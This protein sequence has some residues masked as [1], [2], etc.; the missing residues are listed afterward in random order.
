[1]P[2]LLIF[3]LFVTLTLITQPVQA[4]DLHQW[5][6]RPLGARAV[7]SPQLGF[8]YGSDRRGQSPIHHGLDYLNPRGTPVIA[9]GDGTVIFAGADNAVAVGL[10]PNFYG[11]VVIIQHNLNAPEGGA[12]FTLYGH[13]Y[14]IE[15]TVGQTV[16][17]G[18]QIGQVGATG[19]AIGSHLHFEVRVGDGLNYNATRNPEMW[20]PPLPGTGALIGRM[21]D[22]NGNLVV[23][24][25]YAITNESSVLP[26]FTYNDPNFPR[27]PVFNENMVMS[28]I[29]AGCY[30]IK[31]RGGAGLSY[32]EPICFASGETKV[33]E[34][35][36]Y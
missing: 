12:V 20:Y 21:V 7:Q 5:L 27:D 10:Y 23:G 32:N 19:I 8:T 15:V 11:N 22:G 34:I 30:R 14:K 33:L 18:Q 31:V 3:A 24:I 9:A 29:R 25:R 6:A 36:L 16:T 13:L 26:G 2:R 4:Q 17:T 28:D 1:M 35:K